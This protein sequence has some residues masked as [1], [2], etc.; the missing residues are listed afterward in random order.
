MYTH[1]KLA[2]LQRTVMTYLMIEWEEFVGVALSSSFSFGIRNKLVSVFPSSSSDAAAVGRGR[3]PPRP[4]QDRADDGRSTLRGVPE[5]KH[6]RGLRQASCVSWTG[7][8]CRSSCEEEGKGI[9]LSLMGVASSDTLMG[10]ADC[11][12]EEDREGEE[13]EKVYH[14]L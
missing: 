4:F 6:P 14:F 7:N 1:I 9:P 10:E 11:R 2:R 12:P 3:N 8:I 13:L 5:G